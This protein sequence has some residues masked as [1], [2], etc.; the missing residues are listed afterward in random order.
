MFRKL[1]ILIS[2]VA[3]CLSFV[4]FRVLADSNVQK[5]QPKINQDTLV[6][7]LQQKDLFLKQRRVIIFVKNYISASQPDKV[8]A[9]QDTFNRFFNQY[10]LHNKAAY[11]SFMKGFAYYKQHKLKDAEIE[12]AKAIQKVEDDDEPILLVQFFSHLGFIQTDEGDFIGAIYNYRRATKEIANVKFD[13]KDNRILASLNINL[14]DLYYKTGL[15]AESLNSLNRAMTLLK[16][17]KVNLERLL[18]TIYYN[19]SE[20]FFRKGD[21]DSLQYFNRRLHDPENKNYKLFTYQ[22]RTGYYLSLLRKNY[23]RAIEQITTLKLQKDYVPSELEDQNLADAYYA[24]GQLDSAK[25]ITNRLLATSTDN[26]HPEIKYHLFETLAWIAERQGDTKTAAINYK[27]SLE[28]S[29]QNASRLMQVGDISSQIK[30]DETENSYNQKTEVYERERLW[31]LFIVLVSALSIVAI[32]LF[33][34]NVKQKRHYEKLLYTA[35]REELAFINSHEVRKH[36]TN[37]LGVVDVLKH[38][39]N[40]LADYQLSERYL[41][42]SAEHLDKVIINISEKLHQQEMDAD[43]KGNDK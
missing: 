15:Y 27:L 43:K 6:D 38:S 33:Y 31:L 13:L 40:K 35:Q 18:A 8:Q 23:S 5:P 12:M 9:V 17:D 28:Q 7:I 16:D 21:Y 3:L 34:R 1:L 30:L 29:Q 14:S 25:A 36:V 37:I 42:E 32:A 10:D 4:P 22:Q 39:E 26:N 41:V 19:K 24:S 11:A 20:N 2:C